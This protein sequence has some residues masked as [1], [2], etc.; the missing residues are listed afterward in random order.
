MS[1]QPTAVINFRLFLFIIYVSEAREWSCMYNNT[2]GFSGVK[3][4]Y[5]FV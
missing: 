1:Q 3:L 4:V 2:G 5:H